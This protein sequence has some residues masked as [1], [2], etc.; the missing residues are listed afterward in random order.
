MD[1]I[2]CDMVSQVLRALPAETM[3]D[4]LLWAPSMVIFYSLAGRLVLIKVVV[5]VP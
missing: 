4:G 5:M 2:S 3:V 1:S